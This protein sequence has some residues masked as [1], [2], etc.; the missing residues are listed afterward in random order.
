MTVFGVEEQ[1]I[2]EWLKAH[3]L[4]EQSGLDE[5]TIPPGLLLLIPTDPEDR[6]TA[7]I[8][9]GLTETDRKI[10]NY[11]SKGLPDEVIVESLE[12]ESPEGYW[13]RKEQIL[14]L[15]DPKGP[16]ARI[17][18]GR[19]KWAERILELADELD[20]EAEKIR[21]RK[22]MRI[23]VI[24]SPFFLVACYFIFWPL[25]VRPDTAALFDKYRESVSV[26]T[27]II[28]TTNYN[29]SRWYDAMVEFYSDDPATSQPLLQE[30]IDE[31]TEYLPKARWFL[32]LTYL[33]QGDIRE[34]RSQLS[35]IKEEDP[36]FYQTIPRRLLTDLR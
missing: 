32:S 36:E 23:S 30:L 1:K 16:A 14:K 34:C 10:L 18:A 12:S 15:V 22:R 31:G 20:R 7:E 19:R 3:H 27:T 26:D 35:V 11:L 28:D 9:D 6:E 21:N 8:I 17:F 29:G 2:I 4:D 24:L 13:I 33:R 5:L 25:L